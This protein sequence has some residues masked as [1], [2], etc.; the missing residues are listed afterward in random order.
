MIERWLGWA[1]VPNRYPCRCAAWRWCVARGR[2]ALPRGGDWRD[3]RR[4][5]N[6]AGRQ[7]P[8]QPGLFDAR[9]LTG[10][11]AAT[12]DAVESAK[13]HPTSRCASANSAH[14]SSMSLPGISGCLA[15]RAFSPSVWRPA[16]PA[17]CAGSPSGNAGGATSRILAVR[18]R[19]C[20]RSSTSRRCRSS[21]G[22]FARVIRAFNQDQRPHTAHTTGRTVALIVRPWAV[23][24]SALWRDATSAARDAGA[25]W[26]C[27]F[28]PPTLS[29]IP[30]TGHALRRSLD[31]TMP[32]TLDPDQSPRSCR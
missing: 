5:R 8:I 3:C 2:S 30:A 31:M 24:P 29:I 23:R 25:E 26:C 6:T 17:T 11:Q 13:R 18:P 22:L 20:A 21:A 19:A 27:V 32:A 7:P 9:D 10:S 12:G 16:R 1:T 28:A 14:W 15:A 4:R